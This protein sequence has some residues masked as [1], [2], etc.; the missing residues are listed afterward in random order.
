M[1]LSIITATYN[2]AQE[3]ETCVSS[4]TI[5]DYNN[6]EHILVDGGSTDTTPAL[7][8]KYEQT[9]ENIRWV[10]EPDQGI[11]DALNK[12]IA[13]ATGDVIGFIHSD[14]V[15]ADRK[16]ISKIMEQFKNTKVDGVYGD[17][18]YVQKTNINKT[19][20]EW[21]SCDFRPELLR[22]GWMPAHPTFFLKKAVYQK[23]GH[24]NLAYRI[25]ADYDFMLRVLQDENLSFSYL[26]KVITKMRVG[27]ASN[28]SL[29]NIVQKS[30]EDYKSI[31]SNG[32]SYPLW[33]LLAKNLSKIPQFLLNKR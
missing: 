17:L 5:Q 12:G 10:S 3:L 19:I 2:S 27:G 4:V 1:K 9:H 18:R 29:K 22:Q 28:R 30:K 20:R 33:V 6:I 31:K 8:K 15:L 7:I 24:F 26:P 32:L 21:K 14:D 25:A 16:I 13:M 11:Y 23:H